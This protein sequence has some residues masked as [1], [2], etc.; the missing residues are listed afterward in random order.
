MIKGLSTSKEISQP[1]IGIVNGLNKLSVIVQ[2]PSNLVVNRI[3][4]VMTNE[5][6]AIVSKGV[7]TKG[8]IGKA[9]CSV[10]IIL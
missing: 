1:F 5:A 8:D 7:D 3:L 2:E 10:R 4:I 6:V 9:W